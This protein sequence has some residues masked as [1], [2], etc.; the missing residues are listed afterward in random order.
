MQ[1][2]EQVY[3]SARPTRLARL[4]VYAFGLLLM[5]GPVFLYLIKPSFT[6]MELLGTVTIAGL[7]A[8]FLGFIGFILIMREEWRRLTT[9]Y[10]ITDM[11]ILRQDGILRK[12]T[13]YVMFNKLE[14]IQVEQGLLD[15][16]LGIG[17]ILL[18]TGDDF[19]VLHGIR[20]PRKVEMGIAK[21]L[22][23]HR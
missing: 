17:D 7:I 1:N 15:R 23:Q 2:Q 19:V 8:W 14:R 21:T 18:D 11:R 22:A 9:K 3:Y 10:T 5:I 20:D 12:T 6:S 13:Q 4:H 16:V